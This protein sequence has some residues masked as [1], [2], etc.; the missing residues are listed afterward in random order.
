MVC[1]I[2]K[3]QSTSTNDVYVNVRST[4]FATLRNIGNVYYK[5]YPWVEQ[6]CTSEG[7]AIRME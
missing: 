5:G 6:N 3:V 7:R 1:N 4:L 2:V